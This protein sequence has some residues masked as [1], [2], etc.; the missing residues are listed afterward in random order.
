MIKRIVTDVPSD[1]V[2]MLTGLAA[3]DGRLFRLPTRAKS[4]RSTWP[5]RG[6]RPAGKI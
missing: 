1:Q 2:Q 5:K 4:S 6:A 3:I